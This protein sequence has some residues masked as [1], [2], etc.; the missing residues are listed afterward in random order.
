MRS[1]IHSE[2][3]KIFR[4]REMIPSAVSS[5]FQ[6]S[7]SVPVPALLS[8]GYNILAR[9]F[10]KGRSYDI[11]NKQHFCTASTTTTIIQVIFQKTF[12]VVEKY[13]PS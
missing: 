7:D 10:G 12:A 4:N 5:L 9:L 3:E 11:H 6:F 2:A 8:T 13:S 1:I